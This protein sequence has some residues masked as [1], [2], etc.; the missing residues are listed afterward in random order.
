MLAITDFMLPLIHHKIR[1]V[2]VN[3]NYGARRVTRV[4]TGDDV[5]H[6]ACTASGLVYNGR[7]SRRVIA[8]ETREN[9]LQR[10]WTA[11]RLADNRRCPS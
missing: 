11:R 9:R 7:D 6:S 3:R 2:Q 8:V 5:Q 1:N 10:D 4:V